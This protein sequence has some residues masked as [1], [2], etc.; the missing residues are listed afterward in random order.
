MIR[1]TVACIVLAATMLLGAMALAQRDDDIQYLTGPD[2]R[3]I[4]L[5]RKVQTNQILDLDGD[6]F[7]VTQWFY[8]S[9]QFNAVLTNRGPGDNYLQIR[10]KV[11]V[12]GRAYNWS[13]SGNPGLTGSCNDEERW[14]RA[15]AR[16]AGLKV[17]SLD[18]NRC[19][20]VYGDGSGGTMGTVSLDWDPMK[21]PASSQCT[22]DAYL[23]TWQRPGSGKQK[24]QVQL[25]FSKDG[26]EGLAQAKGFARAPYSENE[27]VLSRI[28]ATDDTCRYKAKCGTVLSASPSC[29]VVVD[30]A[31]VTLTI[32]GGAKIF[33]SDVPWTRASA[34]PKTA[35]CSARD[36]DGN[37]HRSDGALVPIVGIDAGFRDGGNAL[38][39]N[40]PDSWP[41][42]SHKFLRVFREG[43]QESC[44]MSAVCINYDI[45]RS[46]GQTFKRE[47][48]CTLTVDPQ[49][50]TLRES[51]STLSYSRTPRG[52]QQAPRSITTAPPAPPASL[53]VTSAQ[54][55]A[56]I[57]TRERLNREQA[58]F[59]ERQLAENAA[60]KA[61]FDKATAE[62]EATIASQ[63]AETQR[64]EAEYA[65]AM[66]KWRADVEACRQGDFSRCAPQ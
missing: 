64:K 65:A 9:G 16:R 28:Y 53:P 29:T 19:R 48:N 62:R 7:K 46:T 44:K 56:E 10:F 49:R 32:E 30:P 66:A 25:T 35:T 4:P 8:S 18:I 45:N 57:A 60:A 5:T 24:P 33:I 38:M 17:L 36:I 42:G 31:R 21:P 52:G 3:L 55:L 37:W 54:E 34:A 47:R 50:Q 59:A 51:G 23:G 6:S 20:R 14:I 39:F 13:V 12:D 22:P 11:G 27:H 15:V 2:G 26:N 40:H 43:G 63:Q 41:K 1:K 58:A 61:A